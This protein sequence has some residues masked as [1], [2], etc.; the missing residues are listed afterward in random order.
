MP[1]SVLIQPGG[2]QFEL[3]DDTTIL[4][5][6]LDA[7]LT[8][9]YG[10]RDGACG[11]CKGR[12]LEGTVDHGKASATALTE[13]ERAAGLALFCCAKANGPLTIEC[14]Q[15]ASTDDFPVRKLPCRVLR[16]ERAADD[17][18]VVEVKLPATE[19]F[20]FRAGQYIDFLLPGN[21]RRSFSIAN[22]P[23]DAQSLELHIRRVPGGQFTTHVFETMKEKDILR[24]E[25]PLGSF[26]LRED[27]DRPI[28]LL[29][30]GTGF[31]PIKGLIEYALKIGSTRPMSLYWG[32]R[33]KAGLYM[34][35]LAR[36]WQSQ[37]SGFDY[38]PVLSEEGPAQG[39]SGRTG[40]VHQAV[41]Q[42]RPDLSGVQV[43]AC[44][45]PAMIDAARRDFAACGLPD[46][47]FFADAFTYASDP[48]A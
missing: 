7:G 41:M 18:M 48:A 4:Q 13:A 25:G 12:I 20:G 26:Y 6:A 5:G 2:Q 21:R 1:H 36:T 22:A 8:L 9:P 11:S 46:T 28:I 43:Y 45:A 33:D 23:Q 47:Q 40:L 39:W 44:G 31:A 35:Q 3:A 27:S 16:L 37:M 34:D 32:S 42:D 24:F 17:V 10:C 30:G 14:H 15:V 38:V 19:R 29:A